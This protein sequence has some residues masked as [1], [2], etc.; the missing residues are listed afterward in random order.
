MECPSLASNMDTTNSNKRAAVKGTPDSEALA[1][2]EVEPFSDAGGL[3]AACYVKNW[4]ARSL[5]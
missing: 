1:C 2:L 4:Q 5:N 3:F